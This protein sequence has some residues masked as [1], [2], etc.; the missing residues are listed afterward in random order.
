MKIIGISGY[1]QGGKSSLVEFLRG[2]LPSGKLY[3]MSFADSLKKCVYKYWIEPL[4]FR[5]EADWENEDY[6]NRKHPCGLTYRELLQKVGTDWFRSTWPDIW[7]FNAARLTMGLSCNVIFS[8]VRFP[9]E[10]EAIREAGGVLV[11]IVRPGYGPGPDVADRALLGYDGW[12]YVIGGDAGSSESI[13][14]LRVWAD[15]FALWLVGGGPRPEQTPE[16]RAE[17]LK[18]EVA[19]LKDLVLGHL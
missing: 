14:R 3:P 2:A 15:R 13:G 18:V 17:N 4:D 1:K 8:D 7:V 11:K 5:G 19:T 6:K 10:A 16:D 12:D 9:N